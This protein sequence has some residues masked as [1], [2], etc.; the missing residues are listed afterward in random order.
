MLILL[1]SMPQEIMSLSNVKSFKVHFK[2]YDVILYIYLE[3]I[4]QSIVQ[5]NLQV[6]M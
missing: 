2:V 4:I 6:L 1:D 3:L 5:S